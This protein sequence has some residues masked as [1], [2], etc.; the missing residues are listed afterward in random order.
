MIL[1]TLMM[2][3]TVIDVVARY[4]YKPLPGV[5]EMT[6]YCLAVIVF[7]SMGYS[8]IH[9]VHIALD[10]VTKRLPLVVQRI[11]D[12]I[13]YLLAA[14]VFSVACWQMLVYGK[15][16]FD[17]G[18]ITTVVRAPVYPFI[19]A[20]AIGVLFFALAL[21]LDVAETVYSLIKGGKEE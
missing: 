13:L 14:S 21:L 11:L 4:T 17:S 1:I 7:T 20:A 10:L 3:V 5:F 16:L 15:R 8:Q 9:K 12:I 2:F 18:L 6:R 19:Y